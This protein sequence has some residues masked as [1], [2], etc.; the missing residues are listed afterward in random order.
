[1]RPFHI[2]TNESRYS[3]SLFHTHTQTHTLRLY[4]RTVLAHPLPPSLPMSLVFSA[5]R[6][7]KKF[8]ITFL[9]FSFY[10]MKLWQGK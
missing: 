8:Y 9:N 2:Q 3:L 7:K 6:G 4:L 5:E 1:M 10:N